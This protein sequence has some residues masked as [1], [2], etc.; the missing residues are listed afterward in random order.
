MKKA[1]AL[2]ALLLLMN[3]AACASKEDQKA[4]E[5][6]EQA[7]QDKKEAEAKKAADNYKPTLIC[8]QVAII[9]EL[10]TAR[11]FGVEK[12]AA[13]QLVAAA[14][15]QDISGDCGYQDGGIDIAFRV[16][17]TAAKGPRLGG[18]RAE[19]PYFVA[20][21]DPNGA[22]LNKDQMTESFRF[23][24]DPKPVERSEPMHVFIPL[25]KEQKQTGPNY[26]VL[27]G[28]QLTQEQ[29]NEVRATENK[30]KV[31]P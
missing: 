28:F 27:V 19:F 10:E 6:K 4:D 26:R 5:E 16:N 3:F 29:L 23:K 1:C 15:M 2:L 9:R 24:D 31:K 13:G 11:D 14:R 30:V 22:I 25:T 7:E 21:L 12:P 20:V 17:F 8:P 18:D